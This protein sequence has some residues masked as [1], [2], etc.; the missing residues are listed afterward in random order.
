[1]GKGVGLLEILVASKC[2]IHIDKVDKL[3]HENQDR[4]MK[5][6]LPFL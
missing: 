6:C 5:L 3:H 2:A 1:V 4:M